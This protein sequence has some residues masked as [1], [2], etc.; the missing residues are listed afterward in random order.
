[1]ARSESLDLAFLGCGFAARLHSRT[2]RSFPGVRRHYASRDA[3]R[4]ADA[5]RRH[6]GAGAF[7][8]YEQAL[9]SP[10]VDAV[11]VATPPSSHLELTLAALEAG[12]HV[13]VEKPP[14]PS[15]ADFA[16]V[17]EAA[18]RAGRQVLV[19]E[20]YFYK[21]LAIRLRRLLADG[22]VGRPIF[23]HL[24]AVKRQQV[25]DDDWRG[26]PGRAGGG[27]LFEGGI[28]WVD[29][30]ANLGLEL[31]SVGGLRPALGPGP[32][33]SFLVTLQYA[34]GA[35]G[36]LY[37][38]WEVPSLF[39]GLR[40][41]KIYGTEGSITFESNGLIVL[42]RGR[43]KRVI[44]PGFRD[45]AGYRRMFEDFFRCLREGGDPEYSLQH[46][47]RDLRFVEDAYAAAASDRPRDEPDTTRLT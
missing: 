23:V 30:A 5:A 20:N 1:M 40:W 38:S 24:C 7:S 42:V 19:A 22:V 27:A 44:L 11:L 35:V 47:E 15:S 31:E 10:D 28:H 29:L 8:P 41:S 33:R 43:R 26:D 46:A 18:A 45:I 14:F 4:A 16:P 13:I 39:Q 36:A 17:R 12:K 37:H 32:E 25:G 9:A 6:R 34:E 2:L 21:P 3:D